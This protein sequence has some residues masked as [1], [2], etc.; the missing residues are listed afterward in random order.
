MTDPNPAEVSQL[1]WLDITQAAAYTRQSAKHLRTAVG[2]QQLRHIRSG[3][4]GKLSFNRDW[5]DAYMRSLENGD[6]A[7]ETV[8]A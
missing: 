5:L 8:T 4:G 3:R 1:V 7:P 2:T 6:A